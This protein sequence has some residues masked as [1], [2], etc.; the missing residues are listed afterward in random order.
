MSEEYWDLVIK[1]NLKAAIDLTEGLLENGLNNGGSI[2]GLSSISG[3]AGN[4][5]Q[6]NY[7]ASKA[8]MMGLMKKASEQGAFKGINANAIA[9]GFIE[10][11][12]TDKLPFFVKEVARRMS[13]LAQ[14]GKPED[15]AE[16]IR[17]FVS[18]GG[19]VVSG[20]TIRVCGGSFIGR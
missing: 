19:A 14:G 1:I 16:V 17:F 6:T 8:G 13:S 15:I 5:G 9:P 12:M 4:L 2:I 10:T 3:I 18:P 20:Q 11:T 7:S